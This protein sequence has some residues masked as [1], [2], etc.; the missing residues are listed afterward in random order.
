M[1]PG[2]S[3]DRLIAVH[4]REL[5]GEGEGPSLEVDVARQPPHR[6]VGL[7]DVDVEARILDLLGE[8]LERA[9]AQGLRGLTRRAAD[10]RARGLDEPVEVLEGLRDVQLAGDLL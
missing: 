7:R 5:E 4:L 1:G 3:L 6:V 10:R 9:V 8:L 2:W